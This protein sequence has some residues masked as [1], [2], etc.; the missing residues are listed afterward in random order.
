[1]IRVEHVASRQPPAAIGAVHLGLGAFH[2]AHQAVYLERY[3]QRSGDDSW[4]LCSANLRSNVGLVDRLQKAGGRYHVAEY[5]DSEHISLREIGVLR[6]TLFT[7]RDDAGTWGRDLAA[8]LQRMHSPEVRIVILTV[9][10][11]ATS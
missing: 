3:R 8:L 11:R 4:G 2:R 6:E 10:R 5:A 1:M 7:G 9:T